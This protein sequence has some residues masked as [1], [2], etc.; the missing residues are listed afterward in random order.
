MATN[1]LVLFGPQQ[2]QWTTDRLLRLQSDILNNPRL[3]FL[4]QCLIQL[5]AFLAT[6]PLARNDVSSSAQLKSLA[7]FARGEKIPDPQTL[8]NTQLAPLTIV[9]QVT[10]WL[11]LV[12]ESGSQGV[13]AQGFCIGFLTAAA[14][15]SAHNTQSEV[16]RNIANSIRL[17]ACIGLLID[18][19]DA[20][21]VASDR[22]TAISV[23][24]PTFSDRAALETI[25]DQFPEAYISCVTDD[26]TLTITLPHRHLPGLKERFNKDAVATTVIGL[27]G[28]FHHPKHTNA[29]QQL[30]EICAR[31]PDLQL[32]S[33]N[34]LRLS[35]RSTADAE[36]LTTGA[37]H[38]IAIDLILC[39]RAHWFQT[40]KR[41]IDEIPNTVKFVSVGHDSCVPRS[42]SRAK[43]ATDSGSTADLPEE[44]AVVGM[45]CR[46]P[47]ADSL[48]EFWELINSGRTAIG[49]LPISRFNPADISREPKLSTFWGNFL[50]NPDVFDH[51][52]FGISG[53][54]AKSMDPQQ[55][56]ALQVAYEAMEASGYNSVPSASQETDVGCYLGVGAV[57]YEGNVASD[58][59]NAFS[60]TGTLRA[61]ISGR[62]SHF[63]GWT[64]P[65]I[66]FDT[67]CSSSAVAIH[68]ACKVGI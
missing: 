51:R 56:L 19:E 40:V 68:T 14:V 27:N 65:S 43:Q 63:F 49:T 6:T 3:E 17:A 13:L 29:A 66:T 64:G 31:T 7:D 38:D 25:L 42:L 61:F 32:P 55:R 21:H 46:F 36:L 34:Q 37:L 9:A 15:S 45:A 54:E 53:R 23:R 60:A 12:A 10:E 52:F 47:Q 28:C 58:N 20:T 59:A 41:T 8:S 39:K 30:K 4:Q 26:R 22:A 16:E 2:T 11:R 33:A 35:L 50:E 44:I 1:R 5:E 67:A 18:A 24:C 57:D 62:I 48:E